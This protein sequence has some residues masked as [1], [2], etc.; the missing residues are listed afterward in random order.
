MS[1]KLRGLLPLFLIAAIVLPGFG[2]GESK[3]E[4]P[5][6]TPPPPAKS[7]PGPPTAFPARK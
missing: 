1:K 3:P 4:I 6:N 2:C 5:A 7:D